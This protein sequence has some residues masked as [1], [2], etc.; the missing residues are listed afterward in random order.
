MKKVYKVYIITVTFEGYK[1]EPY[2]ITKSCIINKVFSTRQAAAEWITTKTGV[3]LGVLENGAKVYI[4]EEE[5]EEFY[6]KSYRISEH[7]L[8]V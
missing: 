1:Y 4:P 6:M 2:C 7:E 5:H 3:E 8:E